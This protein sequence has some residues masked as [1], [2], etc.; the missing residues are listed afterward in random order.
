VIIELAVGGRVSQLL[1]VDDVGVEFLRAQ[2]D[3]FRER[4]AAVEHD[5]AMGTHELLIA[6]EDLAAHLQK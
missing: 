1:I 4:N 2:A 6:I 5:R 3:T